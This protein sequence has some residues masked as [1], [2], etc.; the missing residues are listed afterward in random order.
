MV[1]RG[2]NDPPSEDFQST[3]QTIF[4]IFP[5]FWYT[6]VD[7]N[8]HLTLLGLT[9]YKTVALTIELQV[10]NGNA[11]QQPAIRPL[12]D[13]RVWRKQQDSHPQH[14]RHVLLVFKTSSSSSQIASILVG[15]VGVA[16]TMFLCGGFTVPCPR[17][18]AYLPILN[19]YFWYG[20]WDLNLQKPV[21]KTGAYAIRLHPHKFGGKTRI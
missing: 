21:S 15:R 14:T 13:R 16:P 11:P 1:G 17:Y 5:Y 8:H 3:A 12:I 4:A 7:S 18:Q 10:H 2:G 6:W 9:A 19:K 20:W